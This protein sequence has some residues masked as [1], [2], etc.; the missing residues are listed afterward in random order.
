MI[1][2]YDPSSIKAIHS[3]QSFILMDIAGMTTF[4]IVINIFIY[5]NI[6]PTRIT[7]ENRFSKITDIWIFSIPSLVIVSVLFPN[8][9]PIQF[10]KTMTTSSLYVIGSQWYWSYKNIQE[11]IDSYLISIKQSDSNFPL[12]SDLILSFPTSVPVSL[13]ITSNDVIHAWTIPKAGIKIDAIP[14]HIT[15][16]NINVLISGNYNGQCSELCGTYHSFMPICINC[17]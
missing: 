6:K 17:I 15:T 14:G 1:Y 9:R 13:S 8:L 2:N 12:I 10:D 4:I 16:A 5:L 11:I 3:I 7:Y